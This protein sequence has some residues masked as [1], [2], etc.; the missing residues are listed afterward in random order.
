[1][2]DFNYSKGESATIP[3]L[4][5]WQDA[6]VDL[7]LVKSVLNYRDVRSALNWCKAHEV[8]VLSQGKTQVVNLIEFI[9]AFYKPYL[10]HLKRTK[11]E[12]WKTVFLNYVSAN[13]SGI[14]SEKREQ[15]QKKN[16]Y[17]PKTNVETAFLK[18][19]KDL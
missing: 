6:I 18:K 8:Y 12:N 10:E 13:V 16:Q 5:N 15:Q 9:L 1:M 19:M 11:K 4:G 2:N 3:T 7:H 17:K 14:L